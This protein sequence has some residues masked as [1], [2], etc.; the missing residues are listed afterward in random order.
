MTSVVP[1]SRAKMGLQPLGFLKLAG[2]KARLYY[3]F[4]GTA[5]VVP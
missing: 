2:A 3:E 4:C 5:E 1:N